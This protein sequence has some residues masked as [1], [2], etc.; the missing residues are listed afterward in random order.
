MNFIRCVAALAAVSFLTLDATAADWPQYRNDA[1]RTGFTTEQIVVPLR[2]QWTFVPQNP[3][4]PAWPDPVREYNI[5]D[6]D[7][8]F[9]AV[10][11]SGL[12]FFGSSADCRVCALDEQTGKVVWTFFTDGP[13]R[14][15]PAVWKDRVFA[16][17]D[18]G[19][20]YGLS[21]KDGR[22]LWKRRIGPS[23]DMI[24]GNGRMI[25]RWPLRSG[26]AVADGLVYCSAGM[27][28]MDKTFMCAL[29]ADD[30]SEAWK[31]EPPEFGPQGCLSL[32]SRSIY[33][34]AGRA[35]MWAMDR[36]GA[37][38]HPVNP[39]ARSAPAAREDV[40]LTG[41]QTHGANENL[42]IAG[43]PQLSPRAVSVCAWPADMKQVIKPPAKGRTAYAFGADACYATGTGRL[44][45]Y[46]L[47]FNPKWEVDAPQQA[48]AMIVADK[49]IVIGGDKVVAFHSADDGKPLGTL[50][51]EGQARGLAVAD[52]RLFVSLDNGRIVCFGA[53]TKADPAVVSN[54]PQNTSSSPDA[55]Q[56]AEAILKDSLVTKGFCLVIG[57]GDLAAELARRTEL[58][59]ICVE[60]DEAKT[61]ALRKSLGEAGLYGARVTVFQQAG[62]K[63]PLPDYFANLVVV[64]GEGHIPGTELYRV[65]R[66][67]GGSAYRIGSAGAGWI[68]G[69]G[70]KMSKVS[71][72]LQKSVRGPL[73]GAADWTHQFANA[74][75]SASS[76]DLL[77]KWPLSVLWFGEPGPAR[78][79]NR[80]LRGSAPV[81]GNG[82]L[83]VLGQHSL[84]ALDAYNGTELW[85]RE[86]PAAQRR[87]VDIL[88][89]NM[90][91]DQD[92][93]YVS[94]AGLCARIAAD[95]GRD[96]R[97]YRL[98]VSGT[99]IS[100][101]GTQT[102][103]V[104]EQNS[105]EMKQTSE[106]I[107]LTLVTRD[108]KVVNADP[109]KDPSHGD[110]W[111][112]F[113]DFRPEAQRSA[114]YGPGVFH[115]VVVPATPER[116]SPSC[117]AG[118]ASQPMKLKAVGEPAADGSRTSIR[119]AWNDVS[120]AS[121][122]R[123]PGTFTFGAILNSSDNGR[124]LASRTYKFATRS[125]YRLADFLCTVSTGRGR[126]AP[127][128]SPL[129]KL[130]PAE[131]MAWGH[132][133]V[134]EDVI[135]GSVIE[136]TDTPD[137]LRFS[138][139]LSSE[140]KDF[141]GPGVVDVLNSVGAGSGTRAIFALN[142]SDGKPRWSYMARQVIP[143]TGICVLDNRVYLIDRP[144]MNLTAAE[145]QRGEPPAGTA[146]LVVL[147]LAT[148]RKITE[149]S[150]GLTDYAGLRGGRGVLLVSSM[151]G[152]TAFDAK[153][154]KILWSVTTKA[155]LE[156]THHCTAFLRT[157]VITKDWVYDDPFAYELRTGKQRLVNNQ[158]W[159]WGNYR[160]CGTVSA[161]ESLLFFR[162][163]NPTI[164]DAADTPVS[165]KFAGI[166]PGCFINIIPACGLALM[167]EASS[168]CACAYNFQT[169]MVLAPVKQ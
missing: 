29:R 95:T 31:T 1:G 72:T 163:S 90:A 60:A 23:A 9:H 134:L 103:A 97:I 167:P 118:P 162:H 152:M 68:S 124:T 116:P 155:P 108:T 26:L 160:G 10:V 153:N 159:V 86:M 129:D 42:P 154:M 77:V 151:S 146:T 30:G 135:L 62:D 81:T 128:A 20:V 12:V 166:R 106:G 47:G 69:D 17:S 76:E 148:G 45:A 36:N 82:R 25:S 79:M 44:G 22:M 38:A 34:P 70:L 91:S 140:G 147:D 43:G 142:K 59:V 63:L 48:F 98:P 52:G 121:A 109:E 149:V 11:S 169:T 127:A 39:Q 100:L 19:C 145:R 8:A 117:K 113:F 131:N 96:G 67:C 150:D 164:L 111:E 18:D 138:W 104:G 73:A 87:V 56:A 112:L 125:S 120:T 7:Y 107:E 2:L 57:S 83:F 3:P 14:F 130:G 5:L 136:Q 21:A 41:P 102:I 156:P 126:A 110:S 89:G 66:P 6:F 132:L 133:S 33:V 119:I 85:S 122:D 46:D 101:S 27:W 49:T 13:V 61:A 168:G 24:I 141:T 64:S 157:P 54:P 115:L 137:A 84:M 94:T 58:N 165:R 78:M 40:V 15:A 123:Q 16:A 35:P 143:H 74:G 144:P 71:K 28:P 88:G 65:L 75:N 50:P 51:V 114:F 99:Q 93:V 80:H 4:M 158:P 37:G 105:I 55:A 139:D 53:D 32:T 92:S 161:S